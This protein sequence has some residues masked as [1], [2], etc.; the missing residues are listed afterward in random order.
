MIPDD[1]YIA[2]GIDDDGDGHI[3]DW[4]YDITTV[5]I[6][7]D[8]ESGYPDDPI[9]WD[10]RDND[11]DVT[12]AGNQHGTAIAGIIA[13]NWGG[14][15]VG[16]APG[17][18]I[19]P[20]KTQRD[21]PCGTTGQAY[22]TK[23]IAEYC[24]RL[25]ADIVSTSQK[26]GTLEASQWATDTL[27]LMHTNGVGNS[28]IEHFQAYAPNERAI[29]VGGTEWGGWPWFDDAYPNKG[30]T[31]FDES[32]DVSA[33]SPQYV[34]TMDCS[35]TAPEGGTWQGTSLSGPIVAG[36]LALMKSAYP[37]W[38]NDFIRA[39]LLASTQPIQPF[40]AN[41]SHP[42]ASDLDGKLGSGAVNAYRA[43]TYYDSLFPPEEATVT[44]NETVWVS[45]DL[46][47]PAGQ[48][49]IIEPGTVIKVAQD[50]ILD[51]GTDPRL[52]EWLIDGTLT[53][54]GTAA[55]PIVFEIFRD[56]EYVPD[57]QTFHNAEFW[58][59]D[60]KVSDPSNVTLEHVE[61]RDLRPR[62]TA[63]ALVAAGTTISTDQVL[64]FSWTTDKQTHHGFQ[65]EQSVR[66][67]TS[68]DGSQTFDAGTTHPIAAGIAVWDAEPVH[69]DLALN[70]L[71]I[72]VEFLDP[73][74]YVIGWD[75]F[76]E[77]HVIEAFDNV[78]LSTGITVPQG[79][80][81]YASTPVDYDSDDSEDLVISYE[82]LAVQLYH[83]DGPFGD[84][85]TFLDRINEDLS[86][87]LVNTRG[88]NRLDY[89][90]D[91]AVDLFFASVTGSRLFE[92]S[93]TTPGD[94]TLDSSSLLGTAA[95]TASSASAWGDLNQDGYLD[96]YIL[97][98]VS[99]VLL[100]AQTNGSGGFASYTDITSTAGLYTETDG[101]SAAMWA[102]LDD[103]G[104]QDLFVTWGGIGGQTGQDPEW[105]Y[106][107]LNTGPNAQGNFVFDDV[108]GELSGPGIGELGLV[109]AVDFADLN[110]DDYLDIVLA[111]QV[112]GG[113]S[114][115]MSN[116]LVCLNDGTGGLRVEMG[117]AVGISTDKE[118]ADVE[119][120][121]LDGNG[122]LDIIGVPKDGSAPIVYLGHGDAANRGDCPRFC[123]TDRAIIAGF[124]LRRPPLSG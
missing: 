41:N 10:F 103:D 68:V 47:V 83:N 3:D 40:D 31:N 8:D 16:V 59:G 4:G 75:D 71:V 49:L 17:V 2:N 116:L 119:V 48:H 90:N 74:G 57:P 77:Y 117:P 55:E 27:G 113:P 14:K 50:D 115:G 104:D 69:A 101:T 61:F 106:Y 11:N 100:Q 54:V 42:F 82:D 80:S 97:Q 7:D 29:I 32:V 15:Y 38:D 67:R 86:S 9:G 91:G 37:H 93:T 112:P 109:H 64:A 28:A 13:A 98:D 124:D 18:R 43:L 76:D 79:S 51:A 34:I 20:I 1:L 58:W 94:V 114:G 63:S 23:E 66:I 44:W 105:S 19:L 52:L 6:D 46:T 95:T 96:V 85:A 111:W 99:D 122:V 53:A 22:F 108:T 60:F 30:G 81:P 118:I 73:N 35:L 78:S 45:G 65:Y 12:N 62:D 56:D 72:R 107:Y 123:V 92:G 70:E 121:D 33:N 88:V 21:V 25:G 26:Y 87:T 110:G 36:V 24:A 84:M 102:D 89:S 39:K 5:Q 120:T